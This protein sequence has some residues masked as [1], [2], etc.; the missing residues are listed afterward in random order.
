MCV[1]VCDSIFNLKFN[2]IMANMLSAPGQVTEKPA[3]AWVACPDILHG[4]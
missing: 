4:S 3:L 1:C 2:N